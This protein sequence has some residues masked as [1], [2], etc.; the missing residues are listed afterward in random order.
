MPEHPP[1]IGSHD[2]EKSGTDSALGGVKLRQGLGQLIG[3]GGV[4]DL[5]VHK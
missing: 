4:E 2:L 5:P 3:R 1:V